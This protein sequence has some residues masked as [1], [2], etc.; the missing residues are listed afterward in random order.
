MDESGQ[1]RNSQGTVRTG[2]QGQIFYF[3]LEVA[4][5]SEISV[6]LKEEIY[7]KISLIL[8]RYMKSDKFVVLSIKN[9]IKISPLM[10]K[11]L[12]FSKY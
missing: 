7:P 5:N 11:T 12:Y 4:E 9:K 10:N 6:C 2:F 8:S 1:P 3:L